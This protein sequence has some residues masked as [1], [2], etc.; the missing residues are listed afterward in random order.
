MD[1]KKKQFTG[2]SKKREF[3]DRRVRTQGGSRVLS[4]GKII[5]E[6]WSYVRLRKLSE[7]PESVVVR[8][9]RLELS[10][11]NAPIEGDNT[12]GE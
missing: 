7:T 8:L 10:L 11:V 12:E 3:F 5:P 6:G 1:K 4:M 9:E 2:K